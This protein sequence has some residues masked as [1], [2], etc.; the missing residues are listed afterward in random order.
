MPIGKDAAPGLSETETGAVPLGARPPPVEEALS[1]T[2]VLI[3]LQLNE[4]VLTLVTE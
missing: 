2:E 3:R 1:Q 4:P